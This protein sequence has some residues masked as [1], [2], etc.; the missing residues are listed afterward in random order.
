VSKCRR[1]WLPASS[2]T[3]QRFLGTARLRR[4]GWLKSERLY[5]QAKHQQQCAGREVVHL[6]CHRVT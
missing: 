5:K 6:V 1:E 4:T 3:L 2:A